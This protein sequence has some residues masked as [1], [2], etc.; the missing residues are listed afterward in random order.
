VTGGRIAF[1]ASALAVVLSGILVSAAFWAPVYNDGSTL[2]DVNGAGVLVPVSVP[3]VLAIAAFG[4]LW[5]R[6]A[7]GSVAGYR[8]A[9]AILGLL[10]FFT[11]LSSFSIGIFVLPLTAL[12]GTAVALTPSAPR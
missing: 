2:V 1:S 7:R 6:C 12:V 10:A 8:A 4:G 3:L 9:V 11:V 5:A